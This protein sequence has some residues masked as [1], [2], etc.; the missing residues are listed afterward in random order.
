VPAIGACRHVAALS[1]APARKTL[2]K[3]GGTAALRDGAA[4]CNVAGTPC[5]APV[6]HRNGAEMPPSD[7]FARP[8]QLRCLQAGCANDTHPPPPQR[9]VSGRDELHQ[10]H[11]VTCSALTALPLQF[12]NAKS[13]FV[14]LRHD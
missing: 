7:S 6:Q 3:A 14:I 8:S 11:H 12:A 10:P 9:G 4:T 2:E 1:L 5:A 13:S